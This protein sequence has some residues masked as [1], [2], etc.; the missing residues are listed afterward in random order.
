MAA[1]GPVLRVPAVRESG[2]IAAVIL[3]SGL[4]ATGLA[5]VYLWLR[6][7]L[8]KAFLKESLKS[9]QDVSGL[10]HPI[11]RE[12]LLNLA[13][14]RCSI[15]K[16]PD[17]FLL[18]FL[19]RKIFFVS[20]LALCLL[21]GFGGI[22]ASAS[23]VL[24]VLQVFLAISGGVFLMLIWSFFLIYGNTHYVGQIRTLMHLLQSEKPAWFQHNF[25]STPVR[26]WL[27]S[28]N[29]VRKSSTTEA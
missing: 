12:Y 9:K 22:L 8:L 23:K 16:K 27:E 13:E 10:R 25:G 14:R 21:I 2:I 6:R 11:V 26:Q 20:T 28:S 5:L 3:V 1:T 29:A 19:P 17:Q 18:G 4:F 24:Y 15:R 7:Q